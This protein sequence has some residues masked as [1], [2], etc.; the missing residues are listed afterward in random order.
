MSHWW[1]WESADCRVSHLEELH[2]V[3]LE[4]P[5]KGSKRGVT[6]PTLEEHG[7]WVCRECG[8]GLSF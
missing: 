7:L 2:P 4:A 6:R 3:G 1:Q 5:W 8:R